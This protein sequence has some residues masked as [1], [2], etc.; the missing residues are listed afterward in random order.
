MRKYFPGLDFPEL[1]NHTR[2]QAHTNTHTHAHKHT[3]TRTHMHTHISQS[4]P[5][6]PVW[7]VL[8]SYL[9]FIF[10]CYLHRVKCHS[11]PCHVNVNHIS[12]I[13]TSCDKWLHYDV[14][15]IILIEPINILKIIF[16][17]G[18]KFKNLKIIKL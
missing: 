4:S 18:D 14:I 7:G 10:F 16:I 5:H 9:F 11:V 1:T 2:T 3:H 6:I 12:Y 13:V 15:M 8:S 17:V